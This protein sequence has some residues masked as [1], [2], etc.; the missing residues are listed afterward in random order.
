MEALTAQLT[1][2][3]QRDYALVCKALGK[4]D[5][6]AY[7]DL[8]SI[9]REPIYFMLLKMTSSK[10]DADDLTM[11]AFSKAFRSLDQYTPNYAFSTWLFR[12][13]T[14]NCI[15]FI[16]KKRAKTVSID[17]FYTAENGENKTIDIQ[18]EALDPEEQAIEKQKKALMRSV[19]G[20]L[21]PS[22]RRLVELRYFEEL[23]YE[24]IAAE[25]NLPLGTVKAKLFRAR[26]LLYNIV[27]NSSEN[28]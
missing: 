24:E 2:K 14:N 4:G 21:K 26:D 17:N 1:Q 23:S 13:A 10:V 12:I 18:S 11:E 16:R 27:K 20:K 6:Q 22:Y 15:D 5:Q 19:V 25:L 9:Y 8:M 28:I 3:A 7:A